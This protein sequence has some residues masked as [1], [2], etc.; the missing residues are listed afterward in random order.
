VSHRTCDRSLFRAVFRGYH[1]N[2]DRSGL[3]LG[4]RRQSDLRISEAGTLRGGFPPA[5]QSE[6][7][8]GRQPRV[9]RRL[10]D[11][12]VSG[13]YCAAWAIPPRLNAPA[14]ILARRGAVYER[15]FRRSMSTS[16][17]RISS[18]GLYLSLSYP[19]NEGANA[20][21]QWWSAVWRR[22]HG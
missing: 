10:G 11:R 20:K 12:W 9:C 16:A 18:A 2:G 7:S 1:G 4:A 5:S 19:H 15:P 22:L 8:L 3:W 6:A 13:G 14:G 21:D 17:L